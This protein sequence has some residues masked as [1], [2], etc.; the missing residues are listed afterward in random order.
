MT[1]F[2]RAGEDMRADDG[3]SGYPVTDPQTRTAALLAAACWLPVTDGEQALLE[4]ADRFAAWITGDEP[5]P[6]VGLA[7]LVPVLSDQLRTIATHWPG[8]M[9]RYCMACDDTEWP[10]DTVLDVVVPWMDDEG[11]EE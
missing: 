6:L 3:R 4:T 2:I 7:R 5:R 1:E 9:T 10:C 11:D 8:A